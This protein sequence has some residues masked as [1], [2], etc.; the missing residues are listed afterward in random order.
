MAFSQPHHGPRARRPWAE[1]R[2]TTANADGA[3]RAFA[4]KLTVIWLMRFRTSIDYDET[5]S[6]RPR[7]GI[8][9]IRQSLARENEIKL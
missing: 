3:T 9:H 8:A 5:R 6:A 2:E 4:A 7:Q 1:R